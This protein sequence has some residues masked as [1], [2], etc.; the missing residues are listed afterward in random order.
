M[1]LLEICRSRIRRLL[2]PPPLRRRPTPPPCSAHSQALRGGS[3]RPP[4][5]PRRQRTTGHRL[6]RRKGPARSGGHSLRARR[7][8]SPSCGAPRAAAAGERPRLQRTAS[9]QE[10]R[11]AFL[12]L[13]RR[14]RSGLLRPPPRLRFL[15]APSHRPRGHRRR[16]TFFRLRPP[17]RG[18]TTAAA[19]STLGRRRR[20][21]W[22][23]A[24]V[25]VPPP[26]SLPLHAG[27]S[28]RVR[29]SDPAAGRSSGQGEASRLQ[30][31]VM[32][33][34]NIPVFWHFPVNSPRTLV[35]ICNNCF[36]PIF[37]MS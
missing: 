28:A 8:P 31:S 35:Y 24:W 11:P 9:L 32:R 13:L 37:P 14:R 7:R 27:A 22:R 30:G 6:W 33:V 26:P 16:A 17:P 5:R 25:Q 23:P 34:L 15:Q 1:S 21:P 18:A 19:G 3:A 29:R 12:L 36:I 20:R 10:R 4:A 2:L